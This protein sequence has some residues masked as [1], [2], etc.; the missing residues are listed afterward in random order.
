M[1]KP[2]PL[3]AV[4]DLM[5]TRSDDAARE[6]GRRLAHE[7][8]AKNQLQ[9]LEDY[10]HDYFERFRTA[11]QH[12][13]SPQQWGN[14]QDFLGKLDEAIS[15]QKSTVEVTASHREEGQRLWLDQ[16]SRLRAFDTLADRHEQKER[17]IEGRREQKVFDEMAA[18]KNHE[19]NPTG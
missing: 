17:G 10:R 11:S 3:Q 2:F 12:G 6:L 16:K 1:S 18:R 9:L 4:L 5:Q 13:M 14:F 8:N 19:G 15:A 7:Q